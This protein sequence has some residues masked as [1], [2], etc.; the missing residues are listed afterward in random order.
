MNRF[1]TCHWQFRNWRPDINRVGRPLRWSG[2]NSFRKRGVSVGDLVYI[3]SLSAG[4][5]YLGGRMVVRGIVSRAEVVRL[6]NNDDLYD[7]E[8]WIVDPQESGTLLHLHRRLS[9]ELTKQLRFLSSS[10]PKAPCFISGTELDRQATRGVREL[11]AE[12]AELLD[13]I[14]EVTDQLPRTSQLITV[15]EAL[16]RAG[17]TTP[18][19]TEFQLPDEVPS[20]AVYSEGSVRTV[21]VNRYE[22]DPQARL[23]CISAHGGSCC[24]CGFNFAAVYGPEAQ[25]YI[26]VHHLR[27]LSEVGGDYIVDPVADLRPVCPNCHAVLHLRGLCLTI[28]EVRRL[29]SEQERRAKG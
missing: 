27:P 20:G 17:G 6:G 25:G 13:R 3:L 2:S 24:V 22:R 21:V 15:T 23:A 28:D 14:I 11:T 26:H 29:M 8:E 7:T 1:W 12:S 18:N 16:L 5:L 19:W 9:P 4:Q 10:G